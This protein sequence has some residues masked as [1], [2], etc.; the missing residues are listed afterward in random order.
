[1]R[2]S[3]ELPAAELRRTER[4]VLSRNVENRPGEAGFGNNNAMRQMSPYIRPDGAV[5]RSAA[6]LKPTNGVERNGNGILQRLP[7]GQA[8]VRYGG[9]CIGTKQ[10]APCVGGMRVEER[11]RYEDSERAGTV[12]V[13]GG[14]C[15]SGSSARTASVSS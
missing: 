3:A 15:C 6:Y 9:A 12:C 4:Q 5:R 13:N 2:V 7:E 11:T 8:Q 10:Y 1:M 14:P